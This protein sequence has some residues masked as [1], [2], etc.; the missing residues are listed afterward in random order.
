MMLPGNQMSLK[1]EG[2]LYNLVKMYV[3][4]MTVFMSVELNACEIVFS[5]S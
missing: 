2:G 5:S 4:G 3:G 1:F